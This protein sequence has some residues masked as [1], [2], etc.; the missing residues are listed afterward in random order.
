MWLVPS[1]TAFSCTKC[2]GPTIARTDTICI[3]WGSLT[4]LMNLS[5]QSAQQCKCLQFVEITTAYS[6]TWGCNTQ[7][8]VLFY[9]S[10]KVDIILL[11]GRHSWNWR[12]WFSEVQL[13]YNTRNEGTQ[14]WKVLLRS[15]SVY[16][17]QMWSDLGMIPW[18]AFVHSTLKSCPRHSTEAGQWNGW[19]WYNRQF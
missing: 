1:N 12:I 15:V 13:K 3:V 5:T 14:P 4:T 10:E 11:A 8:W 7:C 17:T 2:V 9:L 19:W 16:L 18:M 6:W